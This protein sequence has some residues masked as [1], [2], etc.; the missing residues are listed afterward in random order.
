MT[1]AQV[2]QAGVT[3]FPSSDLYF[4]ADNV[5]WKGQ[6]EVRLGRHNV[7]LVRVTLPCDGFLVSSPTVS[8]VA[9]FG[10]T[11]PRERPHRTFPHF[12]PIWDKIRPEIKAKIPAIRAFVNSFFHDRQPNEKLKIDVLSCVSEQRVDIEVAIP[13]VVSLV[14]QF[15]VGLPVSKPPPDAAS[16]KLWEEW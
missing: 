8:R 12:T 7:P 3:G 1:V 10:R 16:A 6:L 11:K 13:N 4:V 14:I 15:E 5:E 9:T 2:E